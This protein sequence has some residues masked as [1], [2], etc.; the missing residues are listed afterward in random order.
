MVQL[1][2]FILSSCTDDAVLPSFVSLHW[3][4]IIL[5]WV[6]LLTQWLRT[7][8]RHLQPWWRKLDLKVKKRKYSGFKLIHKNFLWWKLFCIYGTLVL[9]VA[10]N[11]WKRHIHSKSGK[12][13]SKGFKIKFNVNSF[14][15][16]FFIVSAR[17]VK[18]VIKIKHQLNSITDKNIQNAS[19]TLL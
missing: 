16:H 19:C 10:Y 13:L 5:T 17:T 14:L 11:W 2:W 12:C 18:S 7:I 1:E 15:D 3:Q 6:W 8:I 4:N 9:I